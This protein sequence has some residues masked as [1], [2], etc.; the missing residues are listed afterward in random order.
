MKEFQAKSL[1]E[2]V[3]H[4]QT[5]IDAYE[6]PTKWEE[7]NGRSLKWLIQR[8]NALEM[9]VERKEQK[10]KWKRSEVG[11]DTVLKTAAE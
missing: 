5:Q 4:M 1:E 3:E 10:E 9:A 8:R 6:P 2:K 11:E 7:A